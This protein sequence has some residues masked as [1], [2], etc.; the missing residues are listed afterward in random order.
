MTRQARAERTRDTI[1]Q[2]AG[3][4][5]SRETF[6]QATL[7]DVLREGSVTQ[8]ALYF[9]FD[10]KRSLALEVISRQHALFKEAAHREMV[11]S[12]DGLTAMVALSA[13]L[14]NL[15]TSEPLVQAGLRL[16]TESSPAFEVGIG[17]PYADWVNFAEEFVTKAQASGH[18][19]K[20]RNP[21]DIAW[22][23]MSTFTGVQ[24]VSRAISNWSDL[25]DRLTDMW[26]MLFQAFV[27]EG[28]QPTRMDIEE[29]LRLRYM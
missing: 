5:F 29:T 12:Q 26:E 27:N 6:A 28:L 15:I 2:A 20:D 13:S 9:H 1:I 21:R 11:G 17:A 22:V 24:M 18:I 25:F 8:G 4:V 19:K 7:G 14:A 23:V 3:V 16:S 10:S